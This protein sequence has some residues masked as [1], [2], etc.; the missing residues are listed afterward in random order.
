MYGG[1]KGLLYLQKVEERKGS[2]VLAK[3]VMGGDG[4]GDG[5]MFAFLLFLHCFCSPFLSDKLKLSTK[6]YAF[7][8]EEETYLNHLSHTMVKKMLR[9]RPQIGKQSKR[10]PLENHDEQTADKKIYVAIFLMM[11]QAR[12][13]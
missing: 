11:S 12:V 13:F 1:D 2:A 5:R 9:A 3:G 8:E 6:L 4:E 10:K 7:F